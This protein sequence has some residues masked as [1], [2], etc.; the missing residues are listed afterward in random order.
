MWSNLLRQRSSLIVPISLWACGNACPSGTHSVGSMCEGDAGRIDGGSANEADSAGAPGAGGSGA[1]SGSVST[2]SRSTAG[3]G[4]LGS[5]GQGDQSSGSSTPRCGDGIVDPNETCD[6]Y[7]PTA[8]TCK[9]TS[10]CLKAV[11]EGDPAKCNAT[12]EMREKTDCASGDACCP[13]GCKYATDADCSKSCG[14]GVVDAPEVCEPGSSTQPCPE[15][16]SCQ[17]SGCLK[18]MYVGSALDCTAQCVSTQI[19]A[20]KSGDGCC[21]TGANANT[22][23]DCTSRCGNGILEVGEECEDGA[24]SR[25]NDFLPL[26][27]KY[28]DWNCDA[29][30]CKRRY[31]YTPCSADNQCGSDAS[32]LCDRGYCTFRCVVPETT[33]DPAAALRCTFPNGRDGLCFGDCQLECDTADP[34]VN[35]ECPKSLTCDLYGG[36]STWKL[37]GIGR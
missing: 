37:C 35:Q 33:G 3:T 32:R 4:G 22:D 31:I 2:I 28:D 17:S 30:S 12:C 36:A 9:A 5:A 29:N 16:A 34:N 13:N 19:T 25:G 20:A 24:P 26:G 11:F 6:G 10:T 21:P 7:C 15:P 14:D 1:T 27:Q 23:N 8:S 18:R